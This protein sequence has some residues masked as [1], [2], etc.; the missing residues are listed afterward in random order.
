MKAAVMRSTGLPL[1]IEDIDISD[2]E[3]HEV[4]VRTAAENRKNKLRFPHRRY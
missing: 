4:I 2:P 3:P 1:A